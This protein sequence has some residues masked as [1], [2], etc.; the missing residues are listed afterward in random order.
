[1]TRRAPALLLLAASVAVTLVAAQVGGDLRSRQQGV[2]WPTF[3]GA[4]RNGRSTETAIL[5]RWPQNGPRLLWAV[6]TGEGYSGPTVANGRLFLFDR[7]GD[8]ARLRAFDRETGRELWRSQYPMEYEDYYDYSNGPR[9]SPVIDGDTVYTFGVAGRLRSYSAAD[10]KLLWDVDTTERFGVVK[11]FFGVGSTPVVEG[12][13]L[14]V[15]VGGSPAGSP[16]IHS[17][18]VEGNG[19]GIVAFDKRT[20][21]VRYQVSD[22]LASYASPVVT[23]IDGRRWGF[24]FMRGGLLGFEPATGRIDFHY[25]W[26]SKVLE[27][28][29]AST[30][31]VVGDTVFIS[32]TYGPG[33]SLIRVRPGGYDVVWKDPRRGKALET[34]WNTPVYHD[35]YLYASSGRNTG[36]AEMRCVE[37]ATGKVMWSEPKLK[38]STLLFADGHL[39]VLGEYGMLRLIEA[40]PEAYRVVAEADLHAVTTRLPGANGT[41]RETPLLSFPSWN[42][43]VLSHGILYLRGK[44]TLLALEL[45]PAD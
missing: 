20:G 23:T 35:G 33:S 17:G 6:A 18:E 11:N 45:I 37:H 29:N 2:D 24:A 25:P 40:T 43:P 15:P 3:L 12:D 26:R 14:I 44:E 19:S 39:L 8:Q 36:N 21:E 30:P 22:E 7:Q 32:E 42:A 41:P 28:V 27:S 4:D 34:H 38:R 31:I 13:L 16:K 10:G 5:T 1:M 9:A